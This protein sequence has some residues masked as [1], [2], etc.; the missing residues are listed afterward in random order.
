MNKN[1]NARKVKGFNS[2]LKQSLEKILI[3]NGID[4]PNKINAILYKRKR[5]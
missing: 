5:G 4:K 2:S 3:A 1:K